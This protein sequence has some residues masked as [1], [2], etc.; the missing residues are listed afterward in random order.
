[1]SVFIFQLLDKEIEYGIIERDSMVS[2][3]ILTRKRKED[4]RFFLSV[5]LFPSFVNRKKKE[6]GE[7]IE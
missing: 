4:L 7:K 3:V 6:K 2:I 1:M 5:F